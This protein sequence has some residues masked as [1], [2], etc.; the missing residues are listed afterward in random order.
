MKSIRILVGLLVTLGITV[1]TWAQSLPQVTVLTEGTG[2]AVESGDVVLGALVFKVAEND[3]ILYDSRG[4]QPVS[5]LYVD[6]LSRPGGFLEAIGSLRVGDSVLIQIPAEKFYAENRTPVPEFMTAETPL[7]FYFQVADAMTIEAFQALQKE[8]QLAYR[9]NLMQAQLTQPAMQAKIAQQDSLIEA[10]MVQEGFESATT[11]F[12]V[13]VVI[14]EEGT[15]PVTE[16]GD[17]VTLNYA[18]SLLNGSFFDTSVESVA[19]EQGIYMAG[20]P[21]QP[22]GFELVL[23]QVIVGWHVGILGLP[24]GT[25]AVLLIPSEL[26]YGELG[27]G[28]AIP[29]NSVLRFDIEILKSEKK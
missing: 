12:G 4:T 10:Y 1:P 28:S 22:F 27:R 3:S 13:R 20:R 19:Q 18:G 7:K 23:G 14:V 25:K 6:S 8:Q 9:W 21:Y 11:K 5:L 24:V 16:P 17:Y 26:G 2:D 15:G 29:G